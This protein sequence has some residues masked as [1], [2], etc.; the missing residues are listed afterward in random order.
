MAAAE[1]LLEPAV[2]TDPAT[3]R[4]IRHPVRTSW[5]AVI[6]PTREDPVIRA[7]NR[8]IAA[9]SGTPVDH[10]EPLSVLRY[11]PS[12]HYRPHLDGLAGVANQRV[13]TAIV[14]L[15]Q[16]FRG[17]ETQFPRAG[18]TIVPRTGDAILFRNTLADGRPD[19]HS[20]HAGLRL[21]AGT[22]WVATRWIRARRYDVWRPETAR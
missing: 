7:L 16:G 9:I 22:K 18:L 17:G 14:Y 12:Q 13:W 6:G 15:N 8:R 5:G 1:G 11:A 2:V 21:L 10:G 20:L 3:G 19:P 4:L